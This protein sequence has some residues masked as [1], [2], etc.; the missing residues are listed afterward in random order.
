MHFHL[1]VFFNY[2]D[3]LYKGTEIINEAKK[4]AFQNI[5]RFKPKCFVG[6]IFLMQNES[7][8]KANSYCCI[9]RY[10]K[11][12]YLSFLFNINYLLITVYWHF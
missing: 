8:L 11:L 10:S 2:L 6:C 5:K 4:L 12:K 3:P 1:E 7:K 9:F